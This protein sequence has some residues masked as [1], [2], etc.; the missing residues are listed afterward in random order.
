[1]TDPPNGGGQGAPFA[2]ESPARQEPP[3]ASSPA[4]KAEERPP[5]VPDSTLQQRHASSPP[6]PPSGSSVSRSAQRTLVGVAP[7]ATAGASKPSEANTP[8]GPP[9]G[10]ASVASELPEP[11]PATAPSETPFVPRRPGVRHSRNKTLIGVAP[12][13]TYSSPPPRET[14]ST[15]PSAPP[16][17]ERPSRLCPGP[18]MS[19][20]AAS[21]RPSS[22]RPPPTA[23]A[24][25]ATQPTPAP[26][27]VSARSSHPAAPSARA[28]RA[29]P[30]EPTDTGLDERVHATS[31]S[32]RR[33]D[34][35]PTPRAESQ[36]AAEIQGSAS[37]N[38]PPRGATENKQGE[39]AAPKRPRTRRKVGRALGLGAIC[40]VALLGAWLLRGQLN[41]KHGLRALG[42][43]P[44]GRASPSRVRPQLA[45]P[46]EP[47][48]SA[49]QPKPEPPFGSGET[50]SPATTPDAAA[51]EATAA[52]PASTAP[53]PRQA[54]AA[55]QKSPEAAS[56]GTGKVS[57]TLDVRPLGSKVYFKGRYLGTV[58]LVIELEPGER[59][60][61]EVSKPG[62]VPRRV[63]LDGRRS[64]VLI[65]LKRSSR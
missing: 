7:P 15:R 9:P 37:G 31:E 63:V 48:V 43:D 45:S 5:V 6:K 64:E 62:Y 44:V 34:H 11:T 20:P 49:T 53:V 52:P 22:S 55:G 8:S 38:A 21:P 65:G 29:A 10:T 27:V 13:G 24:A 4:A 17:Q 41:A 61:L 56:G 1:M 25:G 32:T 26:N 14:D 39:V 28:E 36:E 23:E 57:V 54:Q 59:R 2:S 46:S 3:D 16:G 18:S 50:D 12:Q 51:L 30:N 58:P 33:A 40:T 42:E 19:E 60:A 47:S 35:E